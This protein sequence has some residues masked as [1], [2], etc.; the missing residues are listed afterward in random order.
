MRAEAAATPAGL[1]TQTGQGIGVALG[2][3]PSAS[4]WIHPASTTNRRGR[5]LDTGRRR[6]VPAALASARLVMLAYRS[7]GDFRDM[8]AALRSAG[9]PGLPVKTRSFGRIVQG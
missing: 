5:N 3:T 9:Q 1:H 4:G 7:P 8:V 6:V 2:A